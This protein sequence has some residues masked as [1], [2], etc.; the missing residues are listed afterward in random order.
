MRWS[1]VFRA[2][3][4]T[5]GYQTRNPLFWPAVLLGLLGAVLKFGPTITE[6]LKG[7]P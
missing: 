6:W 2:V 5:F 3:K 4:T 1:F 7:L